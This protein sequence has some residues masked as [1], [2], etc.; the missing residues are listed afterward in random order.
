MESKNARFDVN[1][2]KDDTDTQSLQMD[3]QMDRQGVYYRAS[4]DFVWKGPNYSDHH[5]VICCI[6]YLFGYKTVFPSLE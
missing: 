1:A 5:C 2:S 4:I 6:P 3:R